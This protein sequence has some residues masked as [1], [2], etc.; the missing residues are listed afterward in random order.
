MCMS[1]GSALH[2]LSPAPPALWKRGGNI[3]IFQLM[4][5]RLRDLLGLAIRLLLPVLYM[6]LAKFTMTSPGQI[7]QKL[8]SSS[9]PGFTEDHTALSPPLPHPL[10][11]PAHGLGQKPTWS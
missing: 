6:H 8:R 5:P 9:A 3:S 10:L 11:P 1:S 4:K 7:N 2:N